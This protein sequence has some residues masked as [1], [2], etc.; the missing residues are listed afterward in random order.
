MVPLSPPVSRC[1]ASAPA[2]EQPGQ[3]SGLHQRAS[4]WYEAE[5]FAARCRFVIRWPAENFERAASLLELAWSA[6]DIGYQLS[7]WFRLG[8]NAARTGL[9]CPAGPQRRVI[10]G[11]V[12][13]WRVGA[14][15][16]LIS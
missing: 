3:M 10:P 11:A 6:M 7:G 13:C 2:E 8:E 16:S 1:V 15:R 4:A 14:L 12:G 5:R 9:A